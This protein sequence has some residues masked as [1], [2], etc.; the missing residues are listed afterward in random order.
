MYANINGREFEFKANET[1]LDVARRNDVHIPTLCE[2]HDIDHAP[3]TCRVCLVEVHAGDDSAPRYV[4]A[5]DTPMVEGSNVMTRTHKVQA[6]RQ[7]QMEM[8]M[9]DHRQDCATCPRTGRWN[10]R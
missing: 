4:T 10:G 3:G 7:L 9:A 1:I 6:M 2:L 8:T 5:C